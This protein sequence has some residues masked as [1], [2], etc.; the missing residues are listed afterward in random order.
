MAKGLMLRLRQH[1]GSIRHKCFETMGAHRTRRRSS[2][3][4]RIVIEITRSGRSDAFGDEALRRSARGRPFKNP[5]DT[6]NL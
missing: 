5:L 2:R 6:N 3:P 1:T 4:F